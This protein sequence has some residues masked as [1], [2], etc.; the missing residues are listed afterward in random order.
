[1]LLGGFRRVFARVALIDITDL[2]S[3]AGLLLHSFREF[4]DLGA[5]LFIGGRKLAKSVK[6]AK[7]NDELLETKQKS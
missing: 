5:V 4:R 7:F 2:D 6:A 1:V 3:F